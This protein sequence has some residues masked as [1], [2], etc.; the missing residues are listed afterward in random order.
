[1]AAAEIA[2]KCGKEYGGFH[3]LL[4]VVAD[5]DLSDRSSATGSSLVW[6]CNREGGEPRA[7]GPGIWAWSNGGPGHE[8]PKTQ[9]L[10][11]ALTASANGSNVDA[12]TQTWLLEALAD[13]TPAPDE[14]LPETGIGLER[15]RA[16][17]SPSFLLNACLRG[18]CTAPAPPRSSALRRTNPCTGSSAVS[19]QMG[20]TSTG[21]K[22]FRFS[23]LERLA[24]E[25]T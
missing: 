4:G 22:R 20:V 24:D 19:S 25:R 7:L 23:R 16:L 2:F 5:P 9:R 18:L 6:T 8:W 11:S 14:R 3:L 12:E 17:S 15:E 21:R 13:T 1:M 10:I